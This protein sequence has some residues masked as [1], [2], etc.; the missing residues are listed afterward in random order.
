M[1][2][3]ILLMTSEIISAYD[4]VNI[5]LYI[6]QFTYFLFNFIDREK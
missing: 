4:E 6:E 2:K 1:A 3:E 5:Y